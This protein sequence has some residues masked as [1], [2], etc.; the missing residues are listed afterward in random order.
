MRYLYTDSPAVDAAGKGDQFQLNNNK[1]LAIKNTLDNLDKG[2]HG[3]AVKNDGQE[4]I[5]TPKNDEARNALK[6]HVNSLKEHGFKAVQENIDG[7]FSIAK[8]DVPDFVAPSKK[9]VDNEKMIS[10]REE[11]IDKFIEHRPMTSKSKFSPLTA[12]APFVPLALSAFDNP[13]KITPLTDEQKAQHAE[14]V[15]K[16]REIIAKLGLENEINVDDE[17]QINKIKGPLVMLQANKSSVLSDNNVRNAL[18]EAGIHF[19]TWPSL[20]QLRP[21]EP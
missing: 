6:N 10:S 2:G 15:V 21:L 16:A 5:V 12:F 19:G 11:S 4:Y 1:D 7:S 8:E 3:F 13:L 18:K 14:N 20:D 9:P 17:A